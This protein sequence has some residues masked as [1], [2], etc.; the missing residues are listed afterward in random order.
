M[1]GIEAG[2]DTNARKNRS[3]HI[4]EDIVGEVLKEKIKDHP[5]FTLGKE[6]TISFERTKRWDYVIYKNNEPKFLFECNFYNSTGSKPIEVANA[7]VDLQHQINGTGL[8]FVWVTDGKGWKKMVSALQNASK[9]IEYVLN[10][11]MLNE[12]FDKL[13][14]E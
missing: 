6:D 11:K 13:L 12:R 4:F 10:F 14:F 5:E 2:L 7:Y 8:T 1:V 9:D 3:G